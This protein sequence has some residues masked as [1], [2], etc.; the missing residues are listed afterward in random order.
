MIIGLQIVTLLF[1]LC[2]IYFAALHYRRKEISKFEM[3]V[4]LGAWLFASFAIV[5]PDALQSFARTFRFARLFDMMVVGGMILVIIMVS[6]V[7]ITSN[8]IQKKIEK[9]VRKHAI[10]NA[11]K[12]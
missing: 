9:M 10:K 1:S 8:R 5:F 2:M 6:R 12:K 11:G 3:F 4:W 7:Y